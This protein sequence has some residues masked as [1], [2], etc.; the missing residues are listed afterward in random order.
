[1]TAVLLGSISVLADTSELQRRAF[2]EAFAAHDL[3]WSW[4]RDTYRQLLRDSGGAQRIAA[5]ADE[6]GD[7][8]DAD[9]VH[10]TKT[11]RFHALLRDE[12]PPARD[13]VRSLLDDARQR[14]VPVALVTTTSP[15]NVDVLLDAVTDVS[16]DDFAV[17]LDRTGVEHDKPAPDAFLTAMGELGEEAG[18]C[19]AVEDNV[20]GVEAA[21]AAGVTCVAFPNT[22][23][24][25]HDLDAP[26]V[27][28]LD[29]DDLLGHLEPTA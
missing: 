5:Q 23:T 25:G 21:T 24:A 1:M 14:G 18:A 11:E 9:A 3:D 8:V 16:H 26:R 15:D 13:G 10:A 6:R 27:E 20:G 7:D 12:R 17:V 29:L 28:R 2:N 19:V 22:N 4:D